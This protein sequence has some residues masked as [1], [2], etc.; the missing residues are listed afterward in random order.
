M[1]PNAKRALASALLLAACAALAPDVTAAQ[2][3][4]KMVAV[5][6]KDLTGQVLK[7]LG[8]PSQ[9]YCWEQCL[10]EPRC[11]GTRW[12][13]IA[14]STAG[15]CQLMTGDLTFH[16]PTQLKTEDGKTI[17]VTASK[18]EQPLSSPAKQPTQKTE[19]R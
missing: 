5:P 11:T 15:Q 6:G 2:S 18:K 10:D 13:V 14:G 16:S 17:L 12:G 1:N 7:R 4:P 9:N 8:L 3:S 19:P